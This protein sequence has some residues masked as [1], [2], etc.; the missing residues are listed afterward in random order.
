MTENAF[1]GANLPDRYYFTDEKSVTATEIIT[2]RESINWRGDTRERWQ[3]CIEQSLAVIGVRDSESNLVGVAC[4]AGNV[5]HAVLCDLVVSPAHQHKG[6]GAAIMLELLK[7]ADRIGV[8]Y[9]YAELADTNPFRDSMIRSGFK[10]TGD[11]L[12][13]EAAS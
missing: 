12:F 4:L 7:A 2:L 1:V 3:T 13:R 6:I 5:R 11:S 9:L 8:S 10:A